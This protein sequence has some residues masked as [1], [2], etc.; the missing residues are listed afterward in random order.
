LNAGYAILSDYRD[1]T[2]ATRWRK[3]RGNHDFRLESELLTR[4]ERMFGVRPAD[5]PGE[6]EAANA[7]SLRR[8]L[9]LDALGIEL[10]GREGEDWKFGE[11]RVADGLTVRHQ[12]PSKAKLSR[13]TRSVIAGDT[14]RQAIE[15]VTEYGDDDEPRVLALVQT[16]CMA[17]TKGGL[18]YATDADW[19]QGFA[20]AAIHP[21]GSTSFDLATFRAGVLCW[22]GER[23]AA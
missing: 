15:Y 16:G 14:H 20:T 8:L 23:W 1:A 3:L 2:P 17:N 11:I 7:L 5:I 22:R 19:Q 18:G 4:A 12:P 9:H 13:L 6:P 10:V 21:D